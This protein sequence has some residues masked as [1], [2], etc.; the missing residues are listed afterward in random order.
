MKVNKINLGVFIESWITNTSD[1]GFILKQCCP[2][3]FFFYSAPRVNKRGGQIFFFYRYDLHFQNRENF[4]SEF[5]ECCYAYL[6]VWATNYFV[7][8]FYRPH[9]LNV[10]SFVKSLCYFVF[11]ENRLQFEKIVLLVD[12]NISLYVNNDASKNWNSFFEDFGLT[13]YVSEKTHRSGKNLYYVIASNNISINVKSNSLITSS[14]HSII[15]F[16]LSGIKQ[17]KC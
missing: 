16:L 10:K 9:G 2:P 17:R 8:A 4:T 11:E 13:Q 12:F 5:F 6:A 1:D 14:D 7:T 3:A 15:C